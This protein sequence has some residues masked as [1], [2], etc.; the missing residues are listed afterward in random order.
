MS[1]VT[2]S[3]EGK[4]TQGSDI[5]QNEKLHCFDIMIAVT[6][7]KE[8]MTSVEGW[9]LPPSSVP[10]HH[11]LACQDCAAVIVIPPLRWIT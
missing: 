1:G 9:E 8:P 7:H 11:T 2:L 5:F 10:S 4:I 3:Q 6:Q